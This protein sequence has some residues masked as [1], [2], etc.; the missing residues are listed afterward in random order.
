M[1]SVTVPRSVRTIVDLAFWNCTAL[2]E[3]RYP[4][5]I[6]EWNA[7]SKGE[8]WNKGVPAETITPIPSG[9]DIN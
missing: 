9:D 1:T 8:Y 5:S 2:N 7:I 4:G 3:I 6:Q